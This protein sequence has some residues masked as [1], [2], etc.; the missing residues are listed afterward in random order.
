MRNLLDSTHDGYMLQILVCTD[1]DCHVGC[2]KDTGVCQYGGAVEGRP[3]AHC[4]SLAGG[5]GGE[6]R[7]GEGRGG[8]GRGGEGPTGS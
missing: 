1:Q 4:I 6:G 8:E 5:R 7:G 2:G 3:A